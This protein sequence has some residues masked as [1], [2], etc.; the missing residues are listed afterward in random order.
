MK[1]KYYDNWKI[2]S[3]KEISYFQKIVNSRVIYFKYINNKN[4]IKKNLSKRLGG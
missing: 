1:S 2:H 4:K 3:Y